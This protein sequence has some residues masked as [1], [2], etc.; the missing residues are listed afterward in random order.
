[1]AQILTTPQFFKKVLYLIPARCVN[2]V[3]GRDFSCHL[4]PILD[5]SS[6]KPPPNIASVQIL[7]RLTDDTNM[8]DIWRLQHPRDKEYSFCS[9]AHKS[10]IRIGRFLVTSEL[11]QRVNGTQFHNRLISDHS[12]ISL[13]FI[14]VLPL[15]KYY[16][17]LKDT[18]ML[19]WMM[20]SLIMVMVKYL[21]IM[22]GYIIAYETPIEKK[23]FND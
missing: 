18:F 17:L 11:I 10:Y 4:D 19:N 2:V 1:M 9:H 8:V 20:T 7:T 12:P 5:Q 14:N 21:S 3:I 23:D 6:S 16:K 15:Q 13:E 22:R